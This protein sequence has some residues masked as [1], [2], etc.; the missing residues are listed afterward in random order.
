MV[1]DAAREEIIEIG[2][3]GFTFKLAGEIDDLIATYDGLR[4][5][6]IRVQAK[7]RD[8]EVSP[9]TGCAS[10]TSSVR[11]SSNAINARDFFVWKI[12]CL[13]TGASAAPDR[14]GSAYDRIY[15]LF[16]TLCQYVQTKNGSCPTQPSGSANAIYRDHGEHDRPTCRA[17]GLLGDF[18]RTA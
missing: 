5:V 13:R 2:I 11:V 1:F 3:T 7:R 10:D 9:C 14:C 6:V 4:Q 15:L 18:L 12:A 8:W 16:R 17:R